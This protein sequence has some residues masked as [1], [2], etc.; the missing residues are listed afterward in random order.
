VLLGCAGFNG[1]ILSFFGV[2]GY[3]EALWLWFC[4]LWGVW[5]GK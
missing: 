5:L 2:V 4:V 1:K 3:L